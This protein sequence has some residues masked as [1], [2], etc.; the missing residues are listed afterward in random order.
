MAGGYMVIVE[1]LKRVLAVLILGCLFLPLSQCS[2]KAPASGA[3]Q[4]QAA[5]RD[6]YIPIR[7]VSMNPGAGLLIVAIFAWPLAALALR[8]RVRRAWHEIL[9]NIA[10]LLCCATSIAYVVL[11]VRFWGELRYGGLLALIGLAAYFLCSASILWQHARKRFA[12]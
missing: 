1:K 12:Q 5:E 11:V 7:V 10:E 8:Y 3:P 6:V 9:L 2:V 4:T